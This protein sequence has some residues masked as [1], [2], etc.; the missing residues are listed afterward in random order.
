MLKG[1]RIVLNDLE[2]E[3]RDCMNYLSKAFVFLGA[4]LISL[5]T[6][7]EVPQDTEKNIREGFKKSLPSLAIDK[8]EESPISGIYQITSGPVIM[9]V[10]KDAQFA[11]SGDILDLKDGETNIT[12]NA[13]KNARLLAIKNL[14]AEHMIIYEAP[15]SRFE[16]TVLTDIDCGYCRKFHAQVK[17]LN[18]RGITVKYLA[19]PRAGAKSTSYDKAVHVWCSDNPKE[20]MTK[21][22][23]GLPIATKT[24]DNHKIDE[25][26]HLGVMAGVSGT[27]TMVLDDGTLLPGYYDSENLLKILN[28]TR[29]V[30][31]KKTSH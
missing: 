18:K 6:M 31:Q 4:C 10:T 20:A 7:A 30:S 1:E 15:K 29:K 12:E 24:C 22:K 26:F 27:P 19:F 5:Q 17:D 8:I 3:I 11:I 9:Y 16:I 21:A 14:G 25:Q 2:F 28:A 13:R 23:Q